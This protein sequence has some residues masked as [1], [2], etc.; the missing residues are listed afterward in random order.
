MDTL[1][2]AARAAKATVSRASG[3]GLENL[4]SL[5]LHL[6]YF[7]KQGTGNLPP[8]V[9]NLQHS[10]GNKHGVVGFLQA[11]T[12]LVIAALIIPPLIWDDMFLDGVTYA[13]ISKNLADGIGTF[14]QP[15]YTKTLYPVFSEHPLL[16]FW[17]QAQLFKLLGDGLIVERIYTF[18]C[19][20]LSAFGIHALWTLIVKDDN[21]KKHAWLPTLIWIVTPIVFW[22][23][24]NNMLEN[25]M[26]VFVLFSIYFQVSG[27]KRNNPFIFLLG[28]MFLMMAFLTKGPAGLFPLITI[29][30]L[31]FTI[32][33]GPAKKVILYAVIMVIGIVGSSFLLM[34]LIPGLKENIYNY[35]V[36]QLLPSIEG[37]RESVNNRLYLLGK[38]CLELVVP[39]ALSGIFIFRSIFNDSRM[40]G[41]NSDAAMFFLFIAISAS[42]P[43]LVSIK[44]RAYY[45]VPSMPFYALAIATFIVPEI[46]KLLNS[47]AAKPLKMPKWITIVALLILSAISSIVSIKP[48][49]TKERIH[50]IEEISKYIPYGTIIGTNEELCK[51]WWL[52]AQL[53][54][55]GYIS[56]DCSMNH[57]YII[58]DKK[59]FNSINTRNGLSLMDLPLKHFSLYSY[60]E[61]W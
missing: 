45:L 21:Q 29:L 2:F 23:Y 37:S 8:P 52:N 5:L 54:R 9:T 56:L 3:R 20:I 35:I 12:L 16:V 13:A 17:I 6:K 47:I 46:D 24:S 50:D 11:A 60:A 41:F 61:K 27:Y 19:A 44:Q 51:D 22:S 58:M 32:H 42:L 49:Y 1:T 38:L 14:A 40:H 15:H 25:T 55:I 26:S 4:G 10:S 30:V 43:L 36:S 39:I 34:I 31:N 48:S 57:E 28:V 7:P 59:S 53:C 33:P 18:L